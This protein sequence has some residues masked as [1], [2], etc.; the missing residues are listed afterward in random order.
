MVTTK[1]NSRNKSEKYTEALSK[2]YYYC[3]VLL[4]LLLRVTMTITT[5]DYASLLSYH[6]PRVADAWEAKIRARTAR[7]RAARS[8]TASGPPRPRRGPAARTRGTMPVRERIIYYSLK[9]FS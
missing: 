8:Q 3:Y 9:G 6:P 7:G 1:T 5:Y 4:L 2:D